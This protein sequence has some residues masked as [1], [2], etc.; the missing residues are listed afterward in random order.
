MLRLYCR[1]NSNW[2]SEKPNLR[3]TSIQYNNHMAP[4]RTK[5]LLLKNFYFLPINKSCK[6]G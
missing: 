6:N 4:N 3:V 5:V 2:K 1:K